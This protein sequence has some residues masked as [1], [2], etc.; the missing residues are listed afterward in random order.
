MDSDRWEKLKELFDEVRSLS[1]AQRAAFVANVSVR[2]TA[3]GGELAFLLSKD[4]EAGSFLGGGESIPAEMFASGQV[5][6]G[7]YKLMERL[8]R[9]G[10][11][12]V[13]RAR[14][15]QLDRDVAVKFLSPR[16]VQDPSAINRFIRE[17]YAASALNHPNIVT[18]HDAGKT[19]DGRF[20]VMEFIQGRTL[21]QH[22]NRVPVSNRLLI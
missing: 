15:E 10:M 21:R 19:S 4:D 22:I 11:G 6:A 20:I 1:S 8:G 13:Y 16:L 3:M 12:E 9:G 14:D 7:R 17:A 5:V 18:I 2:D